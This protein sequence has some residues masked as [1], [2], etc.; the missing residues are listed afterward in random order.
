MNEISL[1]FPNQLFENHPAIVKS[2]TVALIEDDLFFRQYRFHKK[3]LILH[4]A[5][6]KSYEK[7]LTARGIRTRYFSAVEFPTLGA[8]ILSLAGEGCGKFHFVSTEDY[9]LERRLKRFAS[10]YGIRLQC[11]PS[12]SF[13]C[14][15]GYLD[16]YFAGRKRYF[17]TEFYTEQRKR[18]NILLDDNGLPAGGKW[19]FDT[20]NRRKMPEA[21]H[22]PIAPVYTPSE[23]VREATEYVQ[24]NFPQNYGEAGGFSYPV[25]RAEASSSLTSFLEERFVHYGTYQDAIVDRDSCLFHSLLTPSLNIGLI[26]PAEVLDK[27]LEFS[28][29]EKV[30][31]NSVEGFIRQVLGWREFI[32]AVYIREGVKQRTQNHWGH[33][34]TIPD[35]FRNAT[36]GI[37]PVDNVIQKV[38]KTSYSNHIE[39][40]MVM[41]NF[42]LLC[43]FHPDEVY[44]WFM[45]MYIDA[46]D[47]VMVPNVYGM[48]Q[49]ADGGL[50][51]TKPYISGSNYIVKMSN[52]GKGHWCEIWDSLYWHFIESHRDDFI[53]NPRMSM[54][55]RQC[56]KMD[57]KKKSAL[58]VVRE[59]FISKL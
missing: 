43:G 40:L 14:A 7:E 48:S 57:T 32:R 53:K 28:R 27:T 38:L 15:T 54:M 52:F 1:V 51:S 47:W 22:V 12:P 50:M 41:G 44:R 5:S 17:L 30:P 33:H 25:T 34:N 31:I 8:V 20:E 10:L 4:R 39:R 21:I 36:T 45:E 46:Y 26:T 16:D 49:F 24:I 6:M 35:S 55:A 37:L 2:R 9:L 59:Q 58:R 13:V 11:Y 56:D 23:F 18:L 42:M 3:K 29:R 19:T